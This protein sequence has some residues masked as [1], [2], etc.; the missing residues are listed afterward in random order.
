ERAESVL[1]LAEGRILA[2]QGALDARGQHGPAGGA[3][4]ACARRRRAPRELVDIAGSLL[5]LLDRLFGRRSLGKLLRGGSPSPG[6]A[7]PTAT[8][9]RR[10]AHALERFVE[11][12]LGPRRRQQRRR[13]ILDADADHTLVQLAEL[14][15]Q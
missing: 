6:S 2:Q 11:Q 5:V 15:D 4:Q 10:H 8:R 14:V 7:P 1:G 9:A 12:G 3:L 13:R